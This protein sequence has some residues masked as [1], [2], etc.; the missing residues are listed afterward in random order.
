MPQTI[1]AMPYR[2]IQYRQLARRYF[3]LRH[4]GVAHHSVEA[5]LPTAAIQSG[6][7]DKKAFL[8]IKKSRFHLQA[9]NNRS[10]FLP[11]WKKTDDFEMF[12]E[13]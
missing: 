5:F 13:C 1:M 3:W 2:E 10:R 6:S 7:T 8:M 12:A 11:S 4:R 9:T